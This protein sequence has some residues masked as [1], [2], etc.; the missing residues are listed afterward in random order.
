VIVI[1]WLIALVN[2][3]SITLTHDYICNLTNQSVLKIDIRISF[4]LLMY[5][6]CAIQSRASTQPMPLHVI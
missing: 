2:E 3:I 1:Q 6:I 4:N 5:I